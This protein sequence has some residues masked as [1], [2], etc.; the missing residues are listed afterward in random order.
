MTLTMYHSKKWHGM[1]MNRFGV[2][3]YCGKMQEPAMRDCIQR[4]AKAEG[5][6]MCLSPHKDEGMVWQPP[7]TPD[8]GKGIE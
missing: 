2:V 1:M 5:W 4:E 3:I 8:E 6:T 7:Q